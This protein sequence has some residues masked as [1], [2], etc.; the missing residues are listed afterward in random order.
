MMDNREFKKQKY[1]EGEVENDDE[2]QEWYMPSPFSNQ[3]S[4]WGESWN[5][6]FNCDFETK[7]KDMILVIY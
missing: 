7:I 5:P 1:V 6:T 3:L 2:D 4:S